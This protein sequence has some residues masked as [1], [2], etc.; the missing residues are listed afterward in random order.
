M[1][2]ATET[3]KKPNAKQQECIDN[4]NGV[5][6]VL[7]GPGTGKTFTIIE[8]I[9]NM[10]SN[11]VDPG[12]IL[13]LTFTDAAANEMKKRIEDELG[14]IDCGVQIF[15]YHSFCCS[16]ID[17]FPEEFEIPANYRVIPDSVSRLFIKDCIDEIKPVHFRTEKNDPYFYI[18]TIKTRIASIKQ[19]R[20][21]KEEYIRNL[22]GNPDWEPAKRKL[23]E[24][25]A[26]KYKKGST[27]TTTDENNL[28]KIT[29]KINQAHELWDIYELYQKKM[30]KE[31]YLDFN[32][33]INL[34]LNKF[35]NNA[36]FLH[37]IANRYEY[38]MVDE[39]QDTNASQ[40]EIVFI[41]SHALET[42]NIFV[43]GDDNQII[44][45]FQ[46][47][48]LETIATFLDEFRDKGVKVIC[49]TENMRSTQEILDAARAVIKQDPLNLEKDGRF[50]RYVISKEL[51]AKNEEILAKHKPVRFY[52]YADIMQ[53]YTEIVNEIEKLINSDECPF[54]KE[55]GKKL[56]SQIAILTRTNAEA[57]NFAELMKQRN[58]PYELKEGKNIFTI[59]AV[60]ALYF[61][62]QFLVEPALH[63][64]RI[65]QILTAPP[66]NIDP[67]DYMALF[68]DI[69]KKK[70]FIDVLREGNW[71]KYTEKGQ[72][73]LKKFLETYD[74]LREFQ[75]KENIKNTILEIG[76]K[77]GIFD[78][79]MNT[80]INRTESIAG[81]KCFIDEAVGFSE[82]YGTN[83]LNHFCEYVN[84]LIMDED[85]L[86]TEKAPVNMNAVQLCTYHGSKGREFEYVYMPTLVS[87][88]WESSN[89]S[90]KP[91]IPLDPSEYKTPDEIKEEIKPSDLTKLMYVAMT[92]AKH[93]LRM[94]YPQM[95]NG[96][97][98]QPTKYLV[99][100]QDMFQKEEKP[101]EY[102]EVTFW[103]QAANLLIKGE[104]DYKAE[105]SE[106]IDTLLNDR[107]YSPSAINLYR[108][109]PRRY[110]YED[111]LKLTPQDGN[112]NYLSYGSAVHKA[113]EEAIKY[114]RD[115]K[116]P[117]EK[118]QFIKW[119]KDE[120]SKLPLQSYNHREI[121]EGRGEA[122]LDKYYAQIANTTPTCLYE[123]EYKFEY[124]L[125]DGTKFKGIID[126]LDKNQDGTY[127]IYDYKTGNNKN[128]EIG[129][130]KDHE[131]YYLQMALYK[132]FYECKTGNKVSVTKFIYPEDFESVNDGI[133][134]TEDDIKMAVDTFKQAIADIKDHKFEPATD[135]KKAC[136]YCLYTDYCSMNI[137]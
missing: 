59:P 136:Q 126:R 18:N 9:K 41:L 27:A 23:E 70:T 54:D 115:K 25:L 97:V 61:Y 93:T 21:S 34:V 33:M 3:K 98:K 116:M 114:L 75:T 48:Q 45:R 71:D 118:T 44:Y 15:T 55:S 137:M 72:E 133:E 131:D 82:I 106:F 64:F 76:S 49:L 84:A 124:T 38:I 20:L 128:K 73:Q 12:K 30:D 117:P 56:Y 92:R 42:G 8:R 78:Y 122:A 108:S 134:Y 4:I 99:A 105:F 121:F 7:A 130:D 31:R 58:I 113:C 123:T 86:T 67:K 11:G 85:P 43:V 6:L 104:Y 100:I 1:T 96:K 89:K 57:E 135:R 79:Y 111:I 110:L 129:M 91:D 28:E 120:L 40:N 26:E 13:C 87:E 88:K 119:F 2:A 5:Y 17:E 22:A 102:N 16:V 81:L 50:V 37:D 132:Y 101:F 69:S 60:N 83:Y 46:G 65:F 35:E 90:L 77:T 52:R 74:Y 62:I 103:E 125:K 10:L 66:F 29:K 112:P 109:C 95:I 51:V 47:A 24:K 127:T 80:D 19:H 107:P 63:S 68:G 53:E 94:S 36:G 39:Y 32:D 14:M